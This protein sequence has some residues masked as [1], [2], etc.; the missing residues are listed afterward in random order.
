MDQHYGYID[1]NRG[2]T[3]AELAG[4]L[5]RGKDDDGKP[6]KT[7]TVRKNLIELGCPITGI[8]RVVVIPGRIVLLALERQAAALMDDDEDEIL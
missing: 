7:S 2:Y 1:A 6:I 8:G 5:F 4:V 3:L